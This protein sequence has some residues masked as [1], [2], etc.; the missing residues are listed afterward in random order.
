MIIQVIGLGLIGGS[1]CK[2]IKKRT[3]HTVWGMDRDPAA[4]QKAQ[5]AAAIDAAGT[6]ETLSEADLSI[7]CLYPEETV[8]FLLEHRNHFRKGGL[9]I[10]VCGVKGAV[11]S[12]AAGPLRDSGVRFVGCHPMAG[13]E[14]SGFAYA[15]DDLFDGASFILTPVEET[16]PAAVEEVR[17][18][19][20]SLGFGKTVLSTP[21]EHDRIIAATSQLAHVVSNAYIKSPTAELHKG[22]SA[23]S[24]KD[25][26]RVAWLAPE[27]WAELFLEN[28]DFLMAELDTLMANLRQYQDAM[29][30][31]DLPGLVRL[32]DEGR[33]RK[34]EV[35]GR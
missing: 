22:F 19:A 33:K 16:D 29:V 4:V 12:A 2:T 17:S 7:V 18:F 24:Y 27:M 25:M 21:E 8:S 30:H 28:K 5:A 6:T 15:K 34:E 14:F 9:V 1:L 32:L 13:R 3:S 23:G 26:T 20:R 35:D 11:V 10:D 31:N